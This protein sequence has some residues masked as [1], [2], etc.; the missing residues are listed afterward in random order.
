MASGPLQI[1][2]A[3]LLMAGQS[4]CHLPQQL[5]V[6]GRRGKRRVGHRD[7]LALSPPLGL[8]SVRVLCEGM[9]VRGRL[10]SIIALSISIY[11]SR[12]PYLSIILPHHTYT[13]LPSSLPSLPSPPSL[14]PSLQISSAS[15]PLVMDRRPYTE[16]PAQ[17][18]TTLSHCY[19]RKIRCVP[20]YRT[21]KG[22]QH[23]T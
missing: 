6:P 7:Q 17:T 16:Q 3:L 20:T 5:E 15:P 12:N 13:L 18:N 19:S 2:T 11:L 22:T 9:S 14:T 8:T 21:R 1:L 4:L 10:N 23:F